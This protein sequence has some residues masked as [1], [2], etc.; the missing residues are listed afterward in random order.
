MNDF[1][2]TLIYFHNEL[3]DINNDGHLDAFVCH[4]VEPN[5][6]YLNDL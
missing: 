2:Y 1:R 3:F 6:F 5:V 4:D